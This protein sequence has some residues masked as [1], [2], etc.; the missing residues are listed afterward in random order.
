MHAVVVGVA[1]V[2]QR[3]AVKRI[4]ELRLIETTDG[5]AR[6]P[7]IRTERVGGLEVHAGEL[8]DGLDGAGARG[9]L[10]QIGGGQLRYL[11]RFAAAENN[12]FSHFC[13][14]GGSSLAVGTSSV[15]GGMCLRRNSSTG[16]QH[17]NGKSKRIFVDSKTIHV[18]PLE[19]TERLRVY[20]QQATY[21]GH[22]G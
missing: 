14:S 2:A 21:F 16:K 3:Q 11:A 19:S 5:D 9:N 15:S 12:D 6:G 8:F 4:A 17:G 7:L 1:H 13:G 18:H 10:R 22:S 20:T